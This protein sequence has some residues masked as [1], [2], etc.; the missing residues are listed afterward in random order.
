MLV[1]EVRACYARAGETTH[2]RVPPGSAFVLH[3]DVY[4]SERPAAHRTA[5]HVYA[6]HACVCARIAR[7]ASCIL[8]TAHWQFEL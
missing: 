3:R 1:A 6:L 8:H 7:I 5:A 4:I 2:E